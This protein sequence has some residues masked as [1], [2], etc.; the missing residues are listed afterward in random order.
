[1]AMKSSSL[2]PCSLCNLL[3]ESPEPGSCV[4]PAHD[5]QFFIVEV[6]MCMCVC[7]GG[8]GGGD[9]VSVGVIS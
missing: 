2:S 9:W 3:G 1:M 7:V 5:G 6:C 8:G 4:T